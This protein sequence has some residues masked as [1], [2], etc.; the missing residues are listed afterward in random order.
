MSH[1]GPVFEHKYQ[2]AVV[3]PNLAAIA[4]GPKAV[5]QDEALFNEL[6]NMS[7]TRDEGA[8][9]SVSKEQVAKFEERRDVTELRAQIRASTDKSEKNRLRSR[10]TSIIDTLKRLKLEEDREA[11]FKKADQMRLHGTEPE[12][13]PGAGGPGMAAPV[14]ACISHCTLQG[15]EESAT[16]G[17]SSSEQFIEALRAYLS[18]P[19]TSARRRAPAIATQSKP[20]RDSCC[21]VCLKAYPN[22]SGLTRHFRDTH[23]DDGTFGKP[24]ACRECERAGAAQVVVDGPAQWCNHLEHTHGMVHTPSIKPGASHRDRPSNSRWACL[25]CETPMASVSTLLAHMNRT[26]IPRFRK[27]LH[28]ACSACTREG[29]VDVKPMSIWEWLTHAEAVHNWALPGL[30]PCLLCGHLCAPGAGLRRHFTIQH[31]DKLGE[32]LE[33]AARLSSA[34]PAGEMQGTHDL[35]ELLRHGVEKHLLGQSAADVAGGKR[36]RDR[37]MDGEYTA[38]AAKCTKGDGDGECPAPAPK[39]TEGDG[40]GKY[41]A[42]AARRTE[43]DGNRECPAPPTKRKRA[44]RHNVAYKKELSPVVIYDADSDLCEDVIICASTVDEQQTCHL[45]KNH[46]GSSAALDPEPLGHID[47]SLLAPWRPASAVHHTTAL[48]SGLQTPEALRAA[49]ATPWPLPWLNG[50]ILVTEF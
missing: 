48:S 50:K 10:I 34:M 28:V 30:A 23:L 38:P 31:S 45:T 9:I 43:S 32:Q 39:S 40:D 24:F 46:M 13:T 26:E 14:A 49:A 4:F 12:P 2:T 41:P 33:S 3:R 47:P 21:F 6:R 15:G 5:R 7:H 18:S 36:R 27:S 44:A 17:T 8:P 11:Y 19:V 1:T 16:V 22:R 42:P 37:D 25:L 29:L 20:P 35:E